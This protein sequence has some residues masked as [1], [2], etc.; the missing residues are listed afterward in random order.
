[1]VERGR[2]LGAAGV[3][4]AMPPRLATLAASLL[5]ASVSACCGGFSVV[6][7]TFV[8]RAEL[9]GAASGAMAVRDGDA[10]VLHYSRAGEP[11]NACG[12]D[13]RR[14][15]NLWVRVPS[16]APGAAHRIGEGG[17]VGAYEL[18]EA[19]GTVQAKSVSGSVAFG[20]RTKDGVETTLDL[21]IVL[22]SGEV[23]RL[24]DEYVFHPG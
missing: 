6:R 15:E 20:E 3:S 11:P 5:L 9:R 21:T 12:G 24:D 16:V 1:M 23:V 19:K 4:W 14:V 2:S 22:P 17:V 7:T 8:D 13:A 10:V 18:E